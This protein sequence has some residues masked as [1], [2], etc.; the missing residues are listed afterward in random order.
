MSTIKYILALIDKIIENQ[1]E[2]LSNLS[3]MDDMSA[4]D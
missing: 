3:Q 2:I 1:K 4:N